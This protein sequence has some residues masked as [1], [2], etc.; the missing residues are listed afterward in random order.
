MHRC[1]E[2]ASIGPAKFSSGIDKSVANSVL[3]S[4][5]STMSKNPSTPQVTILIPVYNVGIYLSELLT[6]I[7]EQ[8]Y[9]NFNVL[10]GDDGSTDAPDVI[11]GPFLDD[12][13]FRYI[14]WEKNRG[15]GS[16][17]KD[18]MSEVTTPYWCNP[19]GDDRLHPN[20]LRERL[21]AAS[22]VSNCIMVHGTPHQI[23]SAG[24]EISH[25]PT[26][27]MAR[28]LDSSEFLELLL[29][30]NVVTN[31]GVLVN[32]AITKQC[33]AVMRTD[34]C[35]APDW[36]WWI[37]H[38]SH[39]GTVVFDRT[40]RM[41]YRYH[42]QSLTGSPAK[43]WTRAE[44][45]RRA[46]LLA[47]HDAADYSP[48]AREMLEIFSGPMRALWLSRA[49]KA[50]IGTKGHHPLPQVPWLPGNLGVKLSHLLPIVVSWPFHM[51]REKFARR[52]DSFSQSGIA[53]ARHECLRVNPPTANQ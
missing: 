2:L 39:K 35:Y 44:E 29:Y 21:K 6:S 19:G 18:L 5:H 48:L 33:L 24:H 31:P 8:D 10:I 53:T 43:R 17:M 46:P 3:A 37:L 7:Q 28:H 47:L 13:R 12:S 25:F 45:I 26:F 22:E 27:E 30:H 50:Y 14:R 16:V 32:T 51:L 36:Y 15:L 23:D 4:Q 49:A 52:R 38:A 20:F 1:G 9:T 11:A 42:T 34:L 40:P 41:D